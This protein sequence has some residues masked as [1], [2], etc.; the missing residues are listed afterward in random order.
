[1]YRYVIKNKFLENCKQCNYKKKRKEKN[2]E[3]K[4]SVNC[5]N[6]LGPQADQKRYRKLGP[7]ASPKAQKKLVIICTT[8]LNG[9]LLSTHLGWGS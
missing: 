4:G 3:E 1:M 5:G 8:A 9:S 2:A 6:K 7:Q